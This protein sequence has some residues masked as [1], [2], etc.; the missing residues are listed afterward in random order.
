MSDDNDEYGCVDYIHGSSDR[1]ISDG[2][3]LVRVRDGINGLINTL[4]LLISVFNKIIIG[5]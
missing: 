5:K 3:S 4:W 1:L 2:V